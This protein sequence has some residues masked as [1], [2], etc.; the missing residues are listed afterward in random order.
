MLGEKKIRGD[1]DP[2]V[3]DF[4]KVDNAK[5]GRYYLQP[6]IHKRTEDVPGRPVISNSGY[7]TENISKFLDYHL[8]PLAQGVK[9]YIQDTKHFINKLKNVSN[10]PK[11]SILCTIDVVGLYPNIPHELGLSAMKKALDKREDKSVSTETLLDLAEFVLKNNFFTH[12]DQIF[13]QI[14]GTAMGTVFAP[15]YAILAMAEVEEQALSTFKLQ[16][17]VWWR[18]IDD[19]FLI[20]Q[21]GRDYLDSFLQHL[22]SIHPT[23]KFTNSIST[24]EIEFLDVLVIN[25]NGQIETDL[26]VKKTDTHQYLHSTSCHRYHTKTGIPYGQ[27]LRLRRIISNDDKFEERC[28]D[29][30]NWLLKRGFE[31]GMVATQIDRAKNR[32]RD[33]L[34]ELSQTKNEYD[35]PVLTLRY[36]PSLSAQVH[37]IVKN[38]QVILDSNN[39]L[40][41]VFPEPPRVVYRRAKNL[42]DVLVRATLPKSN[43]MEHAGST[44][45]NKSRCLTCANVQNTNTFCNSSGSKN[46]SIRRGPLSCDTPNVVYLVRCKTCDIQYVGS[47][48]GAFRSRFNNYKSHHRAFLKRKDAGTLGVGKVTPQLAFHSHFAQIGHRGIEDMEFTLIDSACNNTDARKR[49][50]FWQYKLATFEP[51]G[52]NV[53]NVPQ[54]EFG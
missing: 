35:G 8:Q 38:L 29:L 7:F 50:S 4:F 25:K 6:K 11:N 15:S 2:Q 13:R 5:L 1:L 44:R 9:S 27:A 21:H 46:F 17:W 32:N 40:K 14:R 45:C 41:G 54:G 34:L 39:E 28:D 33:E 30:K 20:W 24:K 42:K 18:F 19:I 43:T 31:E 22:N 53:R 36:H 10:L 48:K 37:T 23:L 51:A 52:L 12:N 47:S 26:Y 16:P 3:L 49:E